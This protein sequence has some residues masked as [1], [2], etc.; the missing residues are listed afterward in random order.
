MSDQRETVGGSTGTSADMPALPLAAPRIA[1]RL[2]PALPWL[3][4]PE[5]VAL[6]VLVDASPTRVPNTRSWFGGVV[7]QRGKVLP[8]FDI[9]G[10]AQCEHTARTPPLLLVV[11][12]PA[13]PFVVRSEAMPELIMR[14]D[15]DPALPPH[16]GA[17][18]PYLH[19]GRAHARGPAYE[20]DIGAWL[21]AASAGIA[22]RRDAALL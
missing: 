4:M 7:S 19:A 15:D 20:F 14:G 16:A 5:G 11:D 22:L 3:L 8:V 17:L 12:L 18:A 9:A 13:S 10:W 6:E 1:L 2:H 21:S